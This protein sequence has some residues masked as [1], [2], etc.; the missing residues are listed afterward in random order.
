LPRVV[1]DCDKARHGFHVRGRRELG[2]AGC[3][4][5]REERDGPGR[6]AGD[7]KLLPLGGDAGGERR[8]SLSDAGEVDV[9][10]T[11]A[12]ARGQARRNVRRL[13]DG[14]RGG[15]VWSGSG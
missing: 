9:D 14:R 13:K 15:G 2:L 8:V 3:W 6:G 1:E 5:C 12:Q 11:G 10:R 7:P 4:V